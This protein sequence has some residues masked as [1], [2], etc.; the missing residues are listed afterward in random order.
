MFFT[1]SNCLEII[2]SIS[3][4]I[5]SIFID[6]IYHDPMNITIGFSIDTDEQNYNQNLIGYIVYRKTI[7]NQG[8]EVRY[9]ILLLTIVPSMQRLGYGSLILQEFINLVERRN[10]TKIIV[11][12]TDDNYRFYHSNGFRRT[13]TNYRYRTLYRYEKYDATDYVMIRRL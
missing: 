13:R 5:N 8:L 4:T 3:P 6:N 7:L 12:S 10:F 11:H 1:V 9:Y 2:Q